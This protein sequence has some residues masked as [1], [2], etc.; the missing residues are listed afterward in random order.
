MRAI[1]S[2]Y[3]DPLDTV[4][5]ETA[6]RI[7]LSVARSSDANATTN[8]RGTLFIAAR[9][10]LDPDDC[11]AQM[12]FHELCH[13]L[14]E[15]HDSF[16]KRDWGLDNATN[17]DEPREHAC[18]RAQAFLSE[19]YGLRELL[20]PTTDFRAFYDQLRDPLEPAKDP[21]TQA[22]RIAIRRAAMAP[23]H[24]HLNQALNATRAIATAVA[25]LAERDQLWSKTKP[26][27][28]PHPVGGFTYR[29][30]EHKQCGHCA[31]F[32]NGACTHVASDVA[33][34][35]DWMACERWE[36]AVSCNQCGA[37]CREGYDSV[38][39]DRTEPMIGSHPELVVFR[40]TYVELKR[41]GSRCIAL[42][43]GPETDYACSIYAV[44]PRPC[45]ELEV[46]GQHCLTAR[47]RVGL[48]L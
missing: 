1:R 43:G 32:A 25:P 6:R 30:P 10:H 20:A 46:G 44:R 17:R 41:T 2:S 28:L 48:S 33:V 13:S 29:G 26:P 15:G 35:A 4:W 40:D 23:W 16:S 8:G 9:E 5:I 42:Q 12:I 45:R 21:S 39:I 7:G 3:D 47:Q 38:T 11:L 24:P 19:R 37:C 14:V 36:P 31:W 18:L 34:K 27:T 22:A